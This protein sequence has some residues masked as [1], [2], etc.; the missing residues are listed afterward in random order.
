MRQGNQGG[1]NSELRMKSGHLNTSCVEMI[2]K[3]PHCGH[4]TVHQKYRPLS[5]H[6][7]LPSEQ[8]ALIGMSR[9]AVDGVD[10]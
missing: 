1:V 10:V 2:G 5:L 7:I 4:L 9:E 3:H 6:A 8:P